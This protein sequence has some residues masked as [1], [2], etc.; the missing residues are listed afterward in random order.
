MGTSWWVGIIMVMVMILLDTDYSS[1]STARVT[2]QAPYRGE[3]LITGVCVCGRGIYYRRV[4]GLRIFGTGVPRIFEVVAIFNR[5]K[6]AF[7]FFLCGK[8]GV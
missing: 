5:P 8:L 3:C 4:E 7:F 6:F 1:D 2:G